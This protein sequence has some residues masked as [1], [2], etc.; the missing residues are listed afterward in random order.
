MYLYSGVIFLQ[1]LSVLFVSNV[2]SSNMTCPKCECNCNPSFAPTWEPSWEPSRE[3]SREPSQEPSREPS[4]E[5]SHEP[6]RVPTHVPTRVPSSR[7]VVLP[8]TPVLCPNKKTYCSGCQYCP[9]GSLCSN[10]IW[11]PTMKP[12]PSPSKAP[13]VL[14]PLLPVA[15]TI[16]VINRCTAPIWIGTTSG[17]IPNNPILPNN[18]LLTARGGSYVYGTTGWNG[19]LW[20]KMGCSTGGNGCAI[21]ELANSLVEFNFGNT[22]W[23][24]VSLVDG[25]TLPLRVV[26]SVASCAVAECNLTLSSCPN[27]QYPLLVTGKAC[28]SPCS[29]TKSEANC[30]GGISPSACRNGSV[31]KTEYVELIHRVCPSVYSYSYDDANG[32]HTCTGD[33]VSFT[34]SVC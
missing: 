2:E 9:D 31:V 27:S 14:P 23:Y 26:P 7:P 1:F 6:T 13:V 15:S 17:V 25:Y 30:C 12:A 22:V 19:R 32:L 4:R 8:L 24:D 20:P 28:L 21:G 5:P 11:N 29:Y 3:P 33:G 34:I 18:V 10:C 16:T